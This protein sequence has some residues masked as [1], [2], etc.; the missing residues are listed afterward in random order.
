MDKDTNKIEEINGTKPDVSGSL[1]DD[2]DDPILDIALDIA[3]LKYGDDCLQDEK[4]RVDLGKAY[5][6]I[7][8]LVRQ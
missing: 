3:F 8:K 1:P 6:F 4:F 7:Q 5:D 2:T